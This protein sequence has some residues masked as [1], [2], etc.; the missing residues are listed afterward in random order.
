M[1]LQLLSLSQE[2]ASFFA[3]IRANLFVVGP[4]EFCPPNSLLVF[5][6]EL[7]RAG[8]LASDLDCVYTVSVF[9]VA[10]KHLTLHLIEVRIVAVHQSHGKRL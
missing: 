8:R 3:L 2:S 9:R 5:Q 7:L 1:L 6:I 4:I 10:T